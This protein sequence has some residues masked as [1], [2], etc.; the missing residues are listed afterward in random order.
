MKINW[1]GD[2]E[3]TIIPAHWLFE[4]TDGRKL[5]LV[6]NIKTKLVDFEFPEPLNVFRVSRMG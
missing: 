5:F 4:M 1:L 6:I 2:P 3:A